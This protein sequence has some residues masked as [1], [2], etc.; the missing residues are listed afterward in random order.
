M[1]TR[2]INQDALIKKVFKKVNKDLGIA[3]KTP[4][5]QSEIF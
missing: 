2:K 5:A 1:P 4:T 3:A